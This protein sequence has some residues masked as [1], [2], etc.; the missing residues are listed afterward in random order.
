MLNPPKHRRFVDKESSQVIS[1]AEGLPEIQGFIGRTHLHSRKVVIVVVGLLLFFSLDRSYLYGDSIVIDFESLRHVDGEVLIHG[2][3]YAEDGFL[4]RARHHEPG[5]PWRFNT[6]G[7][8]RP[9]FPGSTTL[10]QG[11]SLGEII[12]TKGDGGI[13]NLTSIELME[14]P[15]LSEGGLSAVNGGSFNI[16]FFGTRADNSIVTTIFTV[17]N[18]LT[19]E[20]YTFSGFTNLVS[21][22]WFQDGGLGPTHQFDNITVE[23]VVPEPSSLLLLVTGL[24]C[25]VARRRREDLLRVKLK[26][27][28]F[29]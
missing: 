19:P 17:D 6:V 10:F 1:E 4:L 27:L 14:L 2:P 3:E 29:F 28:L 7:T 18:F 20:A 12:L 16:E 9:E 24:A 11:V 23:T 8:L 25:L 22:N 21:V 13:F 5:N 15:S 26:A